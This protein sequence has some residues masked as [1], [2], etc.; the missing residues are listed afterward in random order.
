MSTFFFRSLLKKIDVSFKD[1]RAYNGGLLQGKAYRALNE[2]IS[3]TLQPFNLSIPEWKLLGKLTEYD[4]LKPN[5]IAK[6]LDVEPPLVTRLV[7]QLEK[8]N[9]V[10]KVESPDDAR[11][12]LVRCTPEGKK[13][14]KTVEPV[15]RSRLRVLLKDVSLSD[16][17]VYTKVLKSII[18]NA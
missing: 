11:V 17:I 6:I 12:K 13:L 10:E 1:V 14:I 7:S 16:L 18:R 3:D 2:H 15:V 8:N 4:Y 9:F 5:D